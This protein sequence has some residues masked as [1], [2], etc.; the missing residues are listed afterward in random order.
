MHKKYNLSIHV[1]KKNYAMPVERLTNSL[2]QYLELIVLFCEWLIHT[3]TF[4][5]KHELIVQERVYA[6]SSVCFFY[7]KKKKH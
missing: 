5:F 6:V 7:C 2:L 1:Q 3:Y 4:K